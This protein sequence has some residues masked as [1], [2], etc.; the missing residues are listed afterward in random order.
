MALRLGGDDAQLKASMI[1]AILVGM[2]F[3]TEV[4]H[5]DG[6]ATASMAEQRRFYAKLIQCCV[7]LSASDSK[8]SLTSNLAERAF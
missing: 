5:F 1:V 6:I 8:G 3:A 4:V 2:A 7:D